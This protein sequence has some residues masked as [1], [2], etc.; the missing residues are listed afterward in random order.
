MPPNTSPPAD[1]Y[2]NT[3]AKNLDHHLTHARNTQGHTWNSFAEH[4]G[5]SEQTLNN[6]RRGTTSPHRR[7]IEAIEAAAG[8][9]PG[10]FEDARNGQPP[11]P[12]APT[13]HPEFT[14]RLHFLLE[15]LPPTHGDRHTAQTIAGGLNNTITEQRAQ[16]I[17][18]GAAAPTRVELEKLTEYFEIPAGA[19]YFT[20]ADTARKVQDELQLVRALGDANVKNIAMRASGL[21]ADSLRPVLDIIDTLRRAEGLPPAAPGD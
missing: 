14:E 6:I 19:R 7:S 8:W 18:D 4:C 2:K 5:I 17:L 1:W 12:A 20:D 16:D 10:G 21:P 11:A 3:E 15:N 13:P 9:A